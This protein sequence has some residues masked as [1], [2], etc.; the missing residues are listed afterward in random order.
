[1]S[2][3]KSFLVATFFLV[4]LIPTATSQAAVAYSISFTNGQVMLDV[5]PG[6]GTYHAAVV[7]NEE[8]R[9]E[10][11][12][13]LKDNESKIY[14]NNVG[15]ENNSKI[16]YLIIYVDW[17]IENWTYTDNFSMNAFGLSKSLSEQSDSMELAL[18]V[19]ENLVIGNIATGKAQNESDFESSFFEDAPPLS[20]SFD[21]YGGNEFNISKVY[22]E[23]TTKIVTWDFTDITA[24]GGIGCT[25]MVIS[26]EGQTTIDVDVSLSGGGVTISPGAVS[27]TLA[28]GGYI[29][30]PIC[31]LALTKSSYKT[32]QVSALA[33]GRETNTQLNQV[34]KNAGFTVII[35]QYARVSVQASMPTVEFCLGQD[36]IINF[37]AVNNGNYRDTVAV[38]VLN[39]VDL[40]DAG[41][42][43]SLAA[44]QYQIDGAGEQPV[45]ISVSTTVNA[46]SIE[47]PIIVGVS[48]TLQGET[49][50]ANATTMLKVMECKEEVEGVETLV[51][52]LSLLSVLSVLGIISILR[53]R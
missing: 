43:T 39:E 36:L 8:S 24:G 14:T 31:A 16:L 47:I 10:F 50:A 20:M 32:V 9:F 37:I 45:Q 40:E 33:S 4:G 34:N 21:F 15:I 26:N 35:N 22:F 42:T 53:R 13:N 12:D 41:I 46:S 49:A 18:H 7:T 48:T 52:S 51:P 27:V 23:V 3:W 17:S 5:R 44:A 6:S 2:Q 28:P 1:M 19:N 38:E 11:S 25:E 30:V 29:Q